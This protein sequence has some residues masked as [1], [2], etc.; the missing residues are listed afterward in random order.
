VSGANWTWLRIL[1]YLDLLISSELHWF[2]CLQFGQRC[3]HPNRR[4]F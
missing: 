1:S 4:G 2:L 3:H